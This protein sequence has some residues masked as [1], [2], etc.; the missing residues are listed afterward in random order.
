M[1]A[2]LDELRGVFAELTALHGWAPLQTPRNLV[3]ALTGRV[4]AVATIVQWQAEVGPD[5]VTAELR[6]ELGD[7]L[8]YLMALSDALGVDVAD[9]AVTR[10]R[11]AV[12]RAQS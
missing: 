11:G 10:L 12:E 1:T 5:A 8:V 7:C 3:L 6:D 9:D 4:G 2:G